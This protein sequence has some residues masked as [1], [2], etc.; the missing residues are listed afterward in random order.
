MAPMSLKRIKAEVRRMD[1]KLDP[2]SSAFRAAV[3]L[4]SALY[5]GA[6][7]RNVAEF[8]GYDRKEIRRWARNLR[9]AGVWCRGHTASEWDHPEHGGIAFWMDTAVAEGLL[10]R[11][12]APS[13]GAPGSDH[14]AAKEE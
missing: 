14:D 5:V 3:V 4:L 11:S 12:P 13:P 10:K 2:E 6:N 7:E 8:T 1:P 9:A